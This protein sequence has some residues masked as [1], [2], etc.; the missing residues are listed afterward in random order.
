M[1]YNEKR[2]S[3]NKKIFLINT[4]WD[5][6][7]KFEQLYQLGHQIQ[8]LEIFCFQAEISGSNFH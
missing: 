8:F 5:S 2:L 7:L 3:E 1:K 4:D 6:R